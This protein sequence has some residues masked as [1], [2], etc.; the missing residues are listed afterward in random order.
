MATELLLNRLK[1]SE[2]DNAAYATS[3]Y[4]ACQQEAEI[5][6]GCLAAENSPIEAEHA[7]SCILG[8][9]PYSHRLKGPPVFPG[10]QWA[11]IKPVQGP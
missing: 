4:R 6:V 10:V 9:Q 1:N 3:R 5:T 7:D 11:A 8:L 2:L